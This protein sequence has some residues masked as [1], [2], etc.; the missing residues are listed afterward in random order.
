MPAKL[1]EHF[2]PVTVREMHQPG[3]SRC[4][5]LRRSCLSALASRHL[6]LL[7]RCPPRASSTAGGSPR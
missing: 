1:V 2:R 4:H 5:D 6:L 3:R 7:L